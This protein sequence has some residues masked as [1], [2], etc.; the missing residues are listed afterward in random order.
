M[1]NKH[2]P[3][4]GW[5]ES[6]IAGVGEW[7]GDCT[8]LQPFPRAPSIGDSIPEFARDKDLLRQV[9]FQG[10]SMPQVSTQWIDLVMLAGICKMSK[11]S[12]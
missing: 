12:F 4:D 5:I 9:I 1:F 11:Y 7:E 10:A 3:I 6:R 8:R 2:L